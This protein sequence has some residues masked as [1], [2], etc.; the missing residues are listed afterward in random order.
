MKGVFSINMSRQKES[1]NRKIHVTIYPGAF[2]VR[3]KEEPQNGT[4]SYTTQDELTVYE[5]GTT[6]GK[7]I[8]RD[9]I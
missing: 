1:K 3:R 7:K 5:G 8:D 2:N 6:T 9:K 4:P